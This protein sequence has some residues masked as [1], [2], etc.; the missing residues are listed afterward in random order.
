MEDKLIKALVID[1]NVVN[2]IVLTNMLQLFDINVDQADSG[3]QAVAMASK[4]SYD[5]IFVDHVMPQMD[6]VQTTEALRSISSAAKKIIIVALTSSISEDIRRLYQM[7]GANEVYLKPLG[8]LELTSILEKWCPQLSE[9][10]VFHYGDLTCDQSDDTLIYAMTQ[11]IG[12]IDYK[13]GLRYAL[14]DPKHFVNLLKVS[15]KDI[16]TCLDLV[17][18]GN[19]M[20]KRN[21]IRIGVHNMKSVFANIGAIKLSDV[22]NNFEL[23]VSE[24]SSPIDDYFPCF[25]ERI[26]G[27]CDK[28]ETNLN[29]YNDVTSTVRYSET[30]ILLMTQDEY[31][32]CI[33]NTIYYIKRFDY[34]AILSELELLIKRGKPKHKKELEL[35]LAEI[36]EYQYEN[37]LLRLTNIKKEMDTSAISVKHD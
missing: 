37:T 19:R 25:L 29:K 15:L 4:K 5:I 26:L 30:P 31:E 33:L 22:A 20:N 14:G 16:K 8:L 11:E 36:K 34:T 32:Q 7:N 24:E 10:S 28:L 21:D 27:F 1:D 23:I 17:N 2:T 35:A 18:L 13:T 9:G 6:G 12:E 3:S